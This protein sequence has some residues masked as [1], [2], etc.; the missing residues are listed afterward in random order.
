[1]IRPT[2]HNGL[3]V[4]RLTFTVRRY[5]TLLAAALILGV[6]AHGVF[7]A[8]EHHDGARDAAAFCAASAAV[9]A[10]VL[11][12]GSRR[13]AHEVMSVAWLA[14]PRSAPVVSGSRVGRTSAAWLQRF[15][16]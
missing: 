16:N 5:A 6:A 14:L 10:I 1:V 2:R 13:H 3:T 8:I 7:Q 15:Q 11:L 12:V 4:L 9:V